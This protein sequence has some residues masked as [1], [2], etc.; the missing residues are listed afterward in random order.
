MYR[1]LEQEGL[2]DSA[3]WTALATAHRSLGDE[4]A[5]IAMVQ[6]RAALLETAIPAPEGRPD[7]NRLRV[8]LATTLL[9]DPSRH[10]DAVALLSSALK[11]NPDNGEA[12][13]RLADALER[14]GRFDELAVVLEGR[15]PA[16]PPD[17]ASVAMS[18][19]LG[20]ALE[21]AGRRKEAL[22]RYESNPQ[23]AR[24]RDLIGR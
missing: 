12:A 7:R 13:N 14:L 8:E 10:G 16:G 21:R 9:D 18:W 11:E 15:L 5:R 4:A 19:R 6:R 1:E 22:A 24:E 2:T 20:N 23:S 3:A 17:A